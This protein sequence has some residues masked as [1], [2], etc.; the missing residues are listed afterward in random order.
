MTQ[1]A[2]LRAKYLAAKHG[3]T[4]AVT[5]AVLGVLSLVVG[6]M[7]A[8]NPPTETVTQEA[9]VQQVNASVGTSAVVQKDTTAW[10]RGARVN[11]SSL[12]LLS[13][14]PRLTVH[15]NARVP[16]SV[17]VSVTQELTLV[18]SA[19]RNGET[20]WEEREVL[21]ST[22]T[23]VEDGSTSVNATVNVAALDERM[24]EV[25]EE[26][27]TAAS[28][29]T[30]IELSVA[31]DTGTYEGTLTD[32]APLAIGDGAYWLDGSV[33]AGETHSRTVTKTIETSRSQQSV[34]PPMVIGLLSLSA[35]AVVLWYQRQDP[36]PA[37]VERE[38]DHYRAAEWISEGQLPMWLG[39]QHVELDSLMD[40]VDI[41]IDND[42]RVV[43]DPRRDLYAV[44]DGE[45]VYYYSPDKGWDEVPWPEVGGSGGGA[46]QP[47]VGS[48]ED[49]SQDFG[50]G[51]VDE[52]PFA[53]E[54]D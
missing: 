4:I 1:I 18:T 8:A 14:M 31:Y 19:S 43:H 9:D 7:S 40:V 24:D 41:G 44:I 22:E 30:A 33:S 32:R 42:K 27:G 51:D 48:L 49:A 21:A 35:A 54:D 28:V 6:G 50:F 16:A 47:P 29:T 2:L 15:A 36:N 37:L 13:A 26:F 52:T 39:E 34:L 12:Y 46:S 3:R 25:R 45:V 38:M 10:D 11:N 53:D 17:P 20:F 23:T 5:L